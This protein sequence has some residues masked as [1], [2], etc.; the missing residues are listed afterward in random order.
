MTIAQNITT[1]KSQI[2]SKIK[3]IAVSKTKPVSDMLEAYMAGQRAFGENYVQE[4]CDKQTQLPDDIEWHFIGHLQ[5]N[6]VKYIAPFV[7]WI[8]GVESGKLL[9]EINKQAAKH[10]R[11]IRCLLQVHIA[12]EESKFG[13]DSE[14]VLTFCKNTDF[15]NYPFVQVCGLMGMASYSEDESQVRQ[16]F[17]TLKKT[18]DNIQHEVF[19]PQSGFQE[20][21]M[22]MSGDWQVAVEEGSTMVRIGSAIFGS[23]NYIK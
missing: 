10:N 3:L 15:S 8:H 14:E 18:F 16:E 23:R 20:I 9:A 17:S 21:S 2:G 1:L 19:G 5:S 22:G 11:I 4:M 12:T 6:K 13:F 7:S